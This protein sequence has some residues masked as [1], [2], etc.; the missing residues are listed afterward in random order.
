MYVYDVG[1]Y[2]FEVIAPAMLKNIEDL[3]YDVTISWA[4]IHN[5]DNS[6]SIGPNSLRALKMSE[7]GRSAN[8][9]ENH[10]RELLEL[11]TVSPRAGYNQKMMS[12][13][14]LK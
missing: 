7:R 10:G 8:L 13:T 6:K 5:L 2:H 12:L 1:P 11:H 3:V 14:Y 4:M 9:N